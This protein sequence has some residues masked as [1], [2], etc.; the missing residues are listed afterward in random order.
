VIQAKYTLSEESLLEG[1][2]LH[3]QYKRPF[4][5]YYPYLGIVVL[6][7]AIATFNRFENKVFVPALLMGLMFLGTPFLV[8][9]LNKKSIKRLPALG[10]EISWQFDETN[11]SAT[12]QEGD[13][14]QEWANMKDSLIAHNGALI[15][16]QN[17]IFYWV[18]KSAF[19]SPEDFQQVRQFIKNGV[20]KHKIAER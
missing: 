8:R 18:P 19:G 13:F 11:L 15:Y 7:V 14:S 17:N 10:H 9:F 20:P 4:L 2:E 16:Q 6:L 5:K 12:T 1:F 3:F